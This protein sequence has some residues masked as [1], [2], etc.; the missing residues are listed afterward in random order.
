[1]KH[2]YNYVDNDKGLLIIRYGFFLAK[3]GTETAEPLDWIVINET[4]DRMLLVSEKCIMSKELGTLENYGWKNSPLKEHLDGLAN[5]IFNAEDRDL[6]LPN[7]DGEY[8]SLLTAEEVEKYIGDNRKILCAKYSRYGWDEYC[9][10]HSGAGIISGILALIKRKANVSW[11]T[12]PSC[13]D[14]YSGRLPSCVKANGKIKSFSIP[15]AERG[16]RPAI[17]LKK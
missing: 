5:I 15:E 17:I 3:M 2:F 4:S 14:K 12:K 6:L 11:W 7:A 16:V 1:M 13:Y 9:S 10:S 8:L